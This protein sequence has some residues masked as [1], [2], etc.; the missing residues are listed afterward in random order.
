MM[1]DFF[2]SLGTVLAVG[3]QAGLVNKEGKLLNLKKSWL[4]MLWEL[5]LVVLWEL[6]LIR[7]MY[8]A[9]QV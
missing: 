4:L 9:L 8:K 2:D 3:T 7:L 5:L 1:V 6:V